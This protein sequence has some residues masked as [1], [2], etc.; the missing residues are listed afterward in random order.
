MM[1]LESRF[2][3]AG[4]V[5]LHYIEAGSGEPPVVLL[6]GLGSTVTKWRDA[7]PMMASRR[8]TLAVDLPGFGLSETPRARYT[9][10]FLAGGVRA[11]LDDRGIERCVLVGNSLGGVTAMWLA[12]TW[13]ECVD[14]LVLVDPALPLPPGARPD[15]TTVVRMALA[16][17]PGVGEALYTAFMKIKSAEEQV[18]DG[19]RRNVA[20]A[21]RVSPET[22]RLMHDEA[23][24]R[25]RNPALRQPLLSA[26]RHLLWM[27]SARRAEVERVAASLRV[28]TLLVWGSE[29]LL[30]PLAVG[31]H[32][33]GKI[34]GA[35]L[36]VIEGAGH[37]P[38][39]EVP[40]RFAEIVLAFAER[41]EARSTTARTAAVS[42]P[43]GTPGSPG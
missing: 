22:L 9:F 1:A 42:S 10:G 18:A 39:I 3:D 38:Q 11:F 20:D 41:L 4:G 17:I 29:D 31:E 43:S 8:R 27:L 16:Q 15:L 26:Q 6:H 19:L 12:A 13:P 7:L 2:A 32:W 40:D 21:R 37:N 35:E 33:V 14:G 25:R 34:P 24:A 23:E 5:R 28:P 36:L 30:V